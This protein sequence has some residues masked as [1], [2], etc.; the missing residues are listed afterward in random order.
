MKTYRKF[1]GVALGLLNAWLLPAALQAAAPG[2]ALSFNGSSQYVNVGHGASLDVGNTLTLEAWIKPASLDSRHGVFSTRLNNAAGSFQLEVGTA[3]G[4]SCHVVLSGVNTWVAKTS[5]NAITAGQWAHI[6]YVRTGAGAGQQRIYVNGVAQTLLTDAAYSFTNNT[7]DKVIGSGTNGT[8]F[9]P[10]QIDELRVWNVARSQTEIQQSMH[11]ALA[12]SETGLVAYYPFDQSSGTTLPDLTANAN[13]GTLVNM[14]DASWVAS[15]APL[16]NALAFNGTSQYV[17]IADAND[18]DLITHYT[19]ETWF[20]ADAFGGARGLLSKYHAYS[21]NGWLLRLTGTDLDFDQKATSGL[22]LQTGQWY[23]VAAVNNGGTRHLYLNGVEKTLNGEAIAV[24]ANANA[25]RIASDYNGRYFDGQMTETRIWNTARSQA[26]IQDAMHQ[27]LAGTESGLV[28]CYRFDQG[29]DTTLPDLT[30]N[31]HVGTLYASPAWTTDTIPL[32]DAIANRTNIRGVWSSHT[33]SL[34]SGRLSFLN[35]SLSGSHFAVFGHDNATDGWQLSDVPSGVRERLARVWK[36]EASSSPSGTIQIDTTRLDNVGDGS[37]LQLLVD[38]DGTFSNAS[39]VAGVFNPPMFSVAAQTVPTGMYYTL[40]NTSQFTEQTSSG[41]PGVCNSAVAWGD[42]NNDGKLDLLL[43]GYTGSADIS[44][45]YRNNGD[46]TFTD[47]IAGLPSVG[48]GAVAWGDYNNDGWL[49]FILTGNGNSG[50][51]ALIYRNNGNGTFTNISANL[52]GVSYA[53]AAWGDYNNDGLLDIL[54][55]G[56]TGSARITTLYRNNG[57][58]TFTALGADLTGVEFGSV[59]WGDYDSDGLLDILLAGDTGSTRISVIYHNNGNGTFTN[60]SAGLPG[61]SGQAS[62]GDYDNDG[63]LDI[64]LAGYTGSTDISKIYH[65]D[66][67][68]FADISAGLVGV[69]DCAAAWGDYNND[70][71]PDI[72]LAGYTGSTRLSRIYRN[73]GDGSFTNLDASLTGVSFAAAAWGDCDNDGKLDLLLTGSD[74][75]NTST[76]K[77]YQ[78]I[79]TTANTAPVAPEGLAALV[80]RDTV[81]LSWNAGADNQTPAGGLT[82]NVRVGSTSGAADQF[83][84]MAD[85]SSGL[86]RIAALGN[87]GGN[88][89]LPLT[90]TRG[91]TYYWS[92]QTLDSAFAGSPWATEGTFYIMALPVVSTSAITSITTESAQSGGNAS[93]VGGTAITARGIC[94]N[95]T[96]NPTLADAFTVDGNGAGPF[97]SNLAGLGGGGLTYHV[98]AYATSSEG[99]N[100]GEERVF[101]TPMTPQGNAILLDGVNDYVSIA[102]ANNLD[103]TTYYTLEVWFKADAFGGMRGLISKY[104]STNASGYFL[105]LNGTELDFDGKTTSGLNLQAGTWYHVAAVHNNGTRTL[106]LNGLAQTLGGSQPYVGANTNAVR[107]GSDFGSRYFAGRMDEARIWNTSRSVD[108][109][110]DSMHKQLTGSE[111]GLVAC[112]SFNQTAGTALADVTANNHTGTLVNGGAWTAGTVPLADAI[113]S[114]SNIRAVWVGN[115]SSLASGRLS[116]LNSGVSAAQF[117][118][119]GHDNAADAWQLTDVPP[120]VTQR[121]T[122]VWKTETASPTSATIRIDTTGLAGLADGSRLRLLVDDDGTFSNATALSGTYNP[123]MFT[124]TGQ[125]IPDGAFY[126]LGN[127]AVFA[128]QPGAGLAE[129][130]NSDAAWGDYDNDGSLDILI[131]GSTGTS[132]TTRIYHNNSDGT[133]TDID[134]GLPGIEKCALAWGDY[135]ND[136]RLDILLAGSTGSGVITRI[137]HQNGDGTFSDIGA[138]LPGCQNGA[139]AWGDYDNDGSLDILLA[140]SSGSA[141][142]AAIYHNNGDN[143]FTDIGAGLPGL[144]EDCSVAWGDYDNDGS[145]DILLTGSG[146]VSDLTRI[147]HN[148]GDGTFTDIAADLAA[149]RMSSVAWG[150]YNN[151][152]RLDFLLSGYDGNYSIFYLSI[153][154]NNGNGTFTKINT[155]LLGI[156]LGSATWGDYDNDGLLDILLAGQ[157]KN[158]ITTRVYHNNG[159]GAFTEMDAGLAACVN[160]AAAWADFNNDGKL[161]ILVTGA[162]SSGNAMTRLYQNN[163]LSAN[164]VPTAPGGLS[165]S[166]TLDTATLSWDEAVDDQTPAAG[167]TYNVRV[168][169]TP[170]AADVFSGMANTSTGQRRIPAHGNANMNTS[171]KLTLP[172]GGT[173]YWSV[174]AVDSALAGGA[175]ATEGTFAIR[176]LPAVTSDSVIHITTNSAQGGGNVTGPGDQPVTAKGLVWNS[177]ANPSVASHL[178]MSDHGADTGGFTDTM[179]SLT[180]GQTYYLRAYATSSLGTSYGVQRIFTTT[181]TPPGNAIQLDGAND[182]VSIA[183]A[184]DLDLT[185]NY[186]L[187]CWFKADSFGGTG[188]LRGLIGKYQTSGANGYLLRLT[189]TDLDFDQMKT[190][191]LDLQ[192]GQWYHVAAVNSAGTRHL[193]VNGVEKTIS[194]TSYTV[195]ANTD[196]VR[197]GCDFR[198]RYFAG[199]MDEARIWNVVRSQADIQDAMHRELTGSESGLVAYFKFNHASGISLNDVTA[200][201]NDG[202]LI[203]GPTWVTSTLLI[204]WTLTATADAHGAIDPSGNVIVPDGGSQDF[205]ITPDTYHHIADVTKDSVSIGAGPNY[206]WTNVTADGVIHATFAPDLAAGGTPHGWLAEH[207]W[208]SNFDAAEAAD[209][210]GD[211]QSAAQEYLANTDPVAATSVFRV[212]EFVSSPTVSVTFASSANRLYTLYRSTGLT[213]NDWLPV[214]GQTDVP[215][216]GS[217]LTLSDPTS[218]QPPRCFYR[219]GARLP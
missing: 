65:N 124:V 19:L 99:T 178:G 53:A 197:L 192:V 123:P 85:N 61:L 153:Y 51:I 217:P 98:R 129:V 143:T 96:G 105:R 1:K 210:D 134:A 125:T 55:A 86:R 67:G 219:I 182:Y 148:N 132:K 116:L 9:F 107:L 70:G 95:S 25:V 78:S 163:S 198:S 52:T 206:S 3:D 111:S 69:S 176:A 110:R 6:A 64:L 138:R 205:V 63:S 179:D 115:T 29:T 18:L 146:P 169:T 112:Y 140:G 104:Q 168:G 174:Q 118:V 164:T 27:Q 32:A 151:D 187:E 54:V 20:K 22:N 160:G 5:S 218:P 41:L 90:L 21:A 50:R 8:Q 97:T 215:G 202:T 91:R 185:T 122:R 72:L 48:F 165:S 154:Q 39:A 149:F 37:K 213:E 59:A 100:Y 147:Y 214:S 88:R 133:F 139:V 109:I 184:D 12:G 60:I 106:Y 81:A 35:A 150:D 56:D 75:N 203:N 208:T 195:V 159:A 193:Y 172:Q 191:G 209:S 175:W 173:C 170:G 87:A 36:S 28:A 207:G 71:L 152:G 121:L 137:Y 26:D 127:M 68:T 177:S 157:T 62:W 131:A 113:A 49:D 66:N 47:I 199:Q 79:G 117:T 46:G 120:E 181:M 92:V 4:T 183:D 156:V 17:A 7:S 16:A 188:V 130:L 211:G 57:N 142:L 141:E 194:G 136:G 38:S 103:L 200:K 93:S 33:S 80:T 23:H 42:Y 77:L 119:L 108:Q 166:V 190:S 40:A 114:R 135:D 15:S 73:N 171:W 76:T 43:T 83:S 2:N 101:A 201:G 155:G 144:G 44:R 74:Y 89:S 34:A 212:T 102:D 186:T 94:W 167:L 126:T 82:Y 11:H 45:I 84:G 216:T 158:V 180:P 162:N 58:S 10:G 128:E 13:T 189:G 196:E 31:G 24:V 161:D 30:G 14:T 204:G 145:L